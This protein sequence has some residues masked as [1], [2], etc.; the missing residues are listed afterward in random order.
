MTRLPLS[1]LLLAG[2]AIAVPASAQPAPASNNEKI[3]Q[4]IVYGDDKC[5]Q[6]TGDEIIVCAKL[7]EGD[8]YRVPQIFRGGDP[9]DPRNEAWLN[10]VVALERVGRFGTDSCSPV[11]LGGF[12]GCA[13]QLLSG[14]KAERRAANKTDW[15]TMI[16][17]E[18]AKRVAGFDAAA[19]KVEDA[20]V[21]E[22]KALAERQKAAE[23][24]E[25]Q[26]SG[27]APAPAT[28]EAEPDPSPLPVPP[29]KG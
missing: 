1:L 28:N 12:T 22:E 23:Q 19:E 17:D 13:Q 15:Q 6:A 18:R 4:V 20:V 3:N 11:G 25:R 21:A 8:R 14:A 26:A 16:A 24:L 27:M 29:P 5:P 9:L 2:A 7:P 10:R